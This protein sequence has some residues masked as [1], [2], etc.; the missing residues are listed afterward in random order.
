[1]ARRSLLPRIAA[2]A[3]SAQCALVGRAVSV[4]F[5]GCPSDGQTG[6]IEA[7]QGTS[8]PVTAT[9][10]VAERLALYKSSGDFGALA[11][12]G[13]H[14]F[15]VYGSG[16]DLLFITPEPI[17]ASGA[18]SIGQRGLGGPA[19][20]MEYSAGGTSGRFRVAEIIAR[21]FPEYR[22]FVQSVRE[23][24]DTRADQFPAG[25]YPADKLVYP[26]ARVVEFRTPAQAD[27]LGTDARLKKGDSPIDGV[28]ILVGKH[29]DLLLLAVRLS[30]DLAS[31]TPTIV[32]QM[33][34]DAK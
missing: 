29:P 23:M 20:T 15:G 11:P 21:V 22:A 19:I 26:S 1:M 12:R 27:G 24:F 3:L 4:P 25:P 31:L 6:P 34:L 18:F 30:R 32:H 9:R 5:V 7:P 33:E 2:L 17:D 13:W 14:C 16:G 8:V 28:A 10:E